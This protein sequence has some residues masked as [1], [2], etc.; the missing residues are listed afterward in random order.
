MAGRWKQLMENLALAHFATIPTENQHLVRQG[1]T[2]LPAATAGGGI[3][4]TTVQSGGTA[5]GLRTWDRSLVI[6]R[7][8]KTP[9]TRARDDTSAGRRGSFHSSR[10]LG[11]HCP[12]L[13]GCGT[14]G[15]E[16]ARGARDA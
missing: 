12:L 8:G 4:K 5:R 9:D 16:S 15:G 3:S 13:W 14:E 2:Q 6:F 7:T 1:Y 10:A 11:L